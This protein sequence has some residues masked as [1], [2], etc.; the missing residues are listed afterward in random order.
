MGQTILAQLGQIFGQP[1]PSLIIVG[2]GLVLISIDPAHI[3][4]GLHLVSYSTCGE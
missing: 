3:Q 1:G 4:A 2:P